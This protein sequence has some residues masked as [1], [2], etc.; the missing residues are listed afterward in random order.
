MKPGGR[1]QATVRP[2]KGSTL[3][4]L[5][6]CS[7]TQ[8]RRAPQLPP[9]SRTPSHTMEDW[10]NKCQAQVPETQLK[11]LYGFHRRALLKKLKGLILPPQTPQT[12]TLA[13]LA[14]ESLLFLLN[15]HFLF[16]LK[17]PCPPPHLHCA[18]V[19]PPHPHRTP[20]LHSHCCFYKQTTHLP[21]AVKH[22]ITHSD[23]TQ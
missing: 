7:G 1:S 23:K 20:P 13:S 17:P 9:P 5:D 3:S 4:G 11:D 12:P 2:I 10:V 18:R 15:F 22:R 21:A 16:I 19:P 14:Q 6:T 8:P